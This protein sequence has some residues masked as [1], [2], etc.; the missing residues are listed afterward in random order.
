MVLDPQVPLSILP[1]LS[2][3]QPQSFLPTITLAHFPSVPQFLADILGAPGSH[4]DSL[5]LIHTVLM[6]ATHDSIIHVV[7]ITA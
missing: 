6:H 3:S 5:T 2:L 1:G 7:A 4:Y